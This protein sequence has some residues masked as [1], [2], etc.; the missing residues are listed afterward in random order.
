[1]RFK[2]VCLTLKAATHKKV[3]YTQT[4]RELAANKFFEFVWPFCVIDP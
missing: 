4:I 1:M 2:P 3:K